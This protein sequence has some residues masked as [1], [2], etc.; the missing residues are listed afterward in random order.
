M[1][2]HLLITVRL[3]GPRYHGSGEWAPSP[4]RLF[5]ALAAAAS[6]GSTIEHSAHAALEWLEQ[7]PAPV[8]ALPLMRTGQRLSFFGPDNDLDAVGND[9]SRVAGI[10]SSKNVSPR[11]VEAPGEFLYVWRLPDGESA[12]HTQAIRHIAA[13]LYQ[14]GRG[15]DMAWGNSE[16]LDDD[17]LE[18]VLSRH[19]GPVYRPSPGSGGRTLACPRLGSL[20]SLET[21][22]ATTRRRL[23]PSTDPDRELFRQPPKPQFRQVAYDSQPTRRLYETRLQSAESSLAPW[24]LSGAATLVV[25]LRDAAVGRLTT[26]L[27]DRTAEIECMLVGRGPG[28]TTVALTAERVRIIPLPSIGHPHADRAI[29]RVLV[30]VP[31]ACSIPADDVNW[32][33]S[34][35][36]P[37]DEETGEVY[38]LVLTP[39]S[40]DSMLG[41]YGVGE[42]VRARIWRTVTPAALPEARRR[43][44]PTRRLAEAKGGG[45][46]LQEHRGA[47]AAVIQALRHADVRSRALVVRVQREPFEGNG[48][49][50]ERFAPG[51][52]FPKERLWHVEITFATPVSGPLIIG[53]GRFLG[54]GILAPVTHRRGA[55]AF[56]V[57]DGLVGTPSPIE[58]TRALRRAVMARVQAVLPKG[59]QLPTFF[60][61]HEAD[62]SP[63]SS[64]DHLSFVFDPPRARLLIVAPYLVNRRPATRPE[65]RFL[66]MLE[67]ALVGFQELRAGSEGRLRIRATSDPAAE[68]PVF[69]VSR[70]W[71]SVTDY[72]VT[73]HLK[74]VS[75]AEALSTDL[76]L[77]C[78]R[79]GLPNVRVTPGV[80]R[81]VRGR[82]LVGTARL[83]FDVAV[84]G[85]ILLGRSRYFGGGLFVR[86]TA[87]RHA[88]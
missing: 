28:G 71:E 85:P 65:A 26:A 31:P 46:R 54:L 78:V 40:D 39:A 87:G 67:D 52:R 76:R 4:G 9:L 66:D 33:F 18:E 74:G 72:E 42:D 50:V 44:E 34:A 70:T 10:R 3:H 60:S 77:E 2:R 82:G 58:V 75:A 79:R 22:Y 37:V 13:R 19:H 48:E 45:E 11:L 83:D 68:D 38:P 30:E 69:A 25:C 49:R 59:T 88:A 43:I 6:S 17:E 64:A 21:R 56:V 57:E 23:G 63:G 32:A 24:P 62:G 84:E 20:R 86:A 81:G 27:P 80:L 29:R 35:L 15:V 55:Y 73:R 8:V 14:F 41:H 5:Q 53:D 1:S 7:L 47:A 12:V 36:E 61:G 16:I 51:T